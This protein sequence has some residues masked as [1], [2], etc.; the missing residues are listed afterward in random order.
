MSL[1]RIQIKIGPTSKFIVKQLED[2]LTTYMRGSFFHGFL[3]ANYL[4]IRWQARGFYRL[5][6][7]EG[8]NPE[9][10]IKGDRNRERAI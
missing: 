10:T 7:G 2:L 4:T 9:P 6:V 5:I 1:K 8:R 3:S